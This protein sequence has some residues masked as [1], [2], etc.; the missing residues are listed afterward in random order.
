MKSGYVDLHCHLLPGVDD[1]AQDT[2]EALKLLAIAYEEGIR[3]IVTTPHF[4]SQQK[5]EAKERILTAFQAFRQV[6]EERY[7]EILLHLGNELFYSPGVVE[8]LKEERAFTIAGG[9]YV[10]VEFSPRISYNDMYLAVR[11]LVQAR[12]RPVIAHVERYQ[13]LYKNMELCDELVELGAY[14]QMNSQSLVGGLFDENLH[15]CRKLV[16]QGIIHVISTDAHDTG[17]RSPRITKAREWV[18]KKSGK[19]IAE[20]LFALHAEAMIKNE[21]LER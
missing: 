9:K 19:K 12:Y 10:L 14:M 2:E 7:P 8:C 18:E 16:K 21:Y 13:C 3:T 17:G 5:E 15:W 1:G 20:E 4:A 6:V 11:Q